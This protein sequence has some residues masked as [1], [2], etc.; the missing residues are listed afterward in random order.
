MSHTTVFKNIAPNVQDCFLKALEGYPELHSHKIIV[1]GKDLKNTTMQA[2]PVI[3]WSFFNKEKREYHIDVS[4]TT[5]VNNKTKVADI[6]D[7]I[8]TGWFAHEL[9]HVADYRE[10]SALN[11]IWFGLRYQFSRKKKSRVEREADVIA[12]EHGFAEEIIATKKFLMSESNMSEKY[13]KRLLKY[14]MSP[15]D[16]RAILEDK[17][18]IELS[19]KLDEGCLDG[20]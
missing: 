6:S 7:E 20:N 10:R 16:V 5:R 17:K 4:E 9:G 15:E 1:D 11:M 8:L 3:N 12:I 13:K 18:A 19:E 2:Q 14:Y